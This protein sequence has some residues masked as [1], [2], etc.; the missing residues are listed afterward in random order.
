MYRRNQKW[1]DGVP[2]KGFP[3]LRLI[4]VD[5]LLFVG[6]FFLAAF[7]IATANPFYVV[8]AMCLGFLVG[9]GIVIGLLVA[10]AHR[11]DRVYPD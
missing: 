3:W 10:F 8:L 11:R 2:I 4:V 6:Y 7:L 1:R 5:V 9:T